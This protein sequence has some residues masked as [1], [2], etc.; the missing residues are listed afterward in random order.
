M[1]NRET[2]CRCFDDLEVGLRRRTKPTRMGL[3]VVVRKHSIEQALHEQLS[4]R[5]YVP[6]H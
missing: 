4:K 6:V 5:N 1:T 2:K 3:Y